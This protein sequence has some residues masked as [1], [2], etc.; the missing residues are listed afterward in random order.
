M[1]HISAKLIVKGVSEKQAI[2]N[3]DVF[4]AQCETLYTLV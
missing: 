1:R 4:V 2:D 3:S